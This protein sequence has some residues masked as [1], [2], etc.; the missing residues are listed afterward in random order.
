ML[1]EL[2]VLLTSPWIFH[3]RPLSGP[4]SRPGSARFAFCHPACFVRAAC[5]S[6][7]VFTAG[8]TNSLPLAAVSFAAPPAPHDPLSLSPFLPSGV[9]ELP[10][11]PDSSFL[12]SRP[13]VSRFSQEARSVRRRMALQHHD[14]P[15]PSV[16][17]RCSVPAFRP[18]RGTEWQTCTCAQTHASATVEVS[19]TSH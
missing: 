9:L 15:P 10:A 13:G 8:P 5:A 11:A 18:F 2:Q 1:T 16:L 19:P 17:C 7:P 14:P 4:G 3:E 6:S 12:C